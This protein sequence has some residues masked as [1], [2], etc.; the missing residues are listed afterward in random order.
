MVRNDCEGITQKLKNTSDLLPEQNGDIKSTPYCL[1]E[2]IIYNSIHLE[3]KMF[4]KQK[5]FF[6][7]I[8]KMRLREYQG[9]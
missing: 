7:Y 5:D 6:L 1:M 8:T 4:P 2:T 3:L 9:N